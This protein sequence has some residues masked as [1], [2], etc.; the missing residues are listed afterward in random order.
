MRKL[1]VL[2]SLVVMTTTG[3]GQQPPNCAPPDR[4]TTAIQLARQINT[5]EAAV[6]DQTGRYATLVELPVPTPPD[7]FQVQL[8]TDA[9]TYTFSI[10]DIRDAC[11]AAVFSDQAG[12]IYTGTPIR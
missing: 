4:R 11:H 10:K 9:A 7:G 8:S 1:I 2:V 12:L 6:H 5:A 3:M